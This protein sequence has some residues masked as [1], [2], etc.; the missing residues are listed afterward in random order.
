MIRAFVVFILGF[1]FV[2]SLVYA[3]QSITKQQLITSSKVIMAA[4]ITLVIFGAVYLLE[5]S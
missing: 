3:W 1:L 4:I 2:F 5:V